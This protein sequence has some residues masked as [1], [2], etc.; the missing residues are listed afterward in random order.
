MGSKASEAPDRD[1][2]VAQCLELVQG[3]RGDVRFWA[4]VA[5]LPCLLLATRFALELEPFPALGAA[6]A[7]WLPVL[8]LW[9]NRHAEREHA[10]IEQALARFESAFPVKGVGRPQALAA[11]GR[12]AADRGHARHHEAH[13]L[14]A[15]LRADGDAPAPTG[16]AVAPNIEYRGPGAFTGAAPTPAPAVEP[17]VP[18]LERSIPGRSGHDPRP[19][20]PEPSVPVSP[21]QPEAPPSAARNEGEQDGF[22][23]IPLEP[24]DPE[25]R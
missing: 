25:R 8:L 6:V 17:L 19:A 5:V 10:R 22:D 23:Y 20:E 3:K 11:L 4:V 15:E 24:Q 12:V 9:W 13:L 1:A 21:A 14:L 2:V 7:A 16:R 18:E